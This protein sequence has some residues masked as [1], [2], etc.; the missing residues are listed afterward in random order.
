VRGSAINNQQTGNGMKKETTQAKAIEVGDSV[1][2]GA[3]EISIVGT[4][5][6]PPMRQ[7]ITVGNGMPTPHVMAML[8]YDDNFCE[9]GWIPERA[10]WAAQAPELSSDLGKVEN[11]P[12]FK[13][14]NRW[15]TFIAREP[16][17]DNRSAYGNGRTCL[18]FQFTTDWDLLCIRVNQYPNSCSVYDV[19]ADIR[20]GIPK[21]GLTET[22]KIYRNRLMDALHTPEATW[23]M[24]H[25]DSAQ[26]EKFIKAALAHPF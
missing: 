7:S 12:I 18:E 9:L 3:V 21:V 24:A 4:T 1:K 8:K 6:E 14:E 26:I 13:V 22:I 2:I 23:N 19:K 11:P 25:F 16:H 17:K 20:E 10:F 5:G 15:G